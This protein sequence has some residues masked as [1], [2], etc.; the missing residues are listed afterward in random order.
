M[1]AGLGQTKGHSRLQG[2]HCGRSRR[3][4]QDNRG[5]L[6][7]PLRLHRQLPDR[8]CCFVVGLMTMPWRSPC[9]RL[10]L[11]IGVNG[12][13]VRDGGTRGNRGPELKYGTNPDGDARADVARPKVESV[14][15]DRVPKEAAVEVE[16]DVVPYGLQVELGPE[17]RGKDG[18]VV[19]YL[20]SQG[21]VPPD[22]ERRAAELQEHNVLDVQNER[23]E[24]DPSNPLVAG[25]GVLLPGAAVVPRQ[26][27]L[28]QQ[29]H[30]GLA[31]EDH[32]DV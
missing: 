11:L 9:C 17:W 5:F 21:A 19:A 10:M 4:L 16:A 30:E 32:H 2:L 29:R 7:R 18:A 13:V 28:D 25:L 14:A 26:D 22:K 31:E 3:E 27:P 1:L 23:L 15:F 12:S 6:L 24:S 8:V 20:G